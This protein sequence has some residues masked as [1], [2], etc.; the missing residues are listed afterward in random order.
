MLHKQKYPVFSRPPDIIITAVSF[1]GKKC[2]QF[3]LPRFF[4]SFLTCLCS[5]GIGIDI[6]QA[7][8]LVF[9]IITE[10]FP[11]Y[12]EILTM[13]LLVI[14]RTMLGVPEVLLQPLC[15][16]AVALVAN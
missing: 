3:T 4:M 7:E 5:A 2:K 10:T 15:V 1:E 16:E 14:P 6:A 8:R 11:R 12:A 13:I 9:Y